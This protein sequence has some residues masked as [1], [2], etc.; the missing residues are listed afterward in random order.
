MKL[1]TKQLLA[2]RRLYGENKLNITKLSNELHV[3]RGTLSKA[4]KKDDANLNRTT[5]NKINNWI[6]DQYT[7]TNSLS[8]VQA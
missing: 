8:E 7:P 3:S 6:I 2:L 1:T 4:L 5:V